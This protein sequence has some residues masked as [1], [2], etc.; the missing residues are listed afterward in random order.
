MSDLRSDSPLEP[1]GATIDALVGDRSTAISKPALDPISPE[2]TPTVKKKSFF[3]NKLN[4]EIYG[5]EYT[6]D[7][8]SDDDKQA[9]SKAAT[10]GGPRTETDQ[11]ANTKDILP[12]KDQFDIRKG[13]LD[14]N[15]I[16]FTDI[17]PTQS[18]KD[19]KGIDYG[20]ERVKTQEDDSTNERLMTRQKENQ[21]KKIIDVKSQKD[22]SQKKCQRSENMERNNYQRE[23]W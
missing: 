15:S 5:D 10:N 22:Q 9:S 11:Q 18:Q 2:A 23:E 19:W 17:N 7:E 1:T 13:K 12:Q 6:T 20:K 16:L 14:N 4:K 21:Y 8:D 3:T